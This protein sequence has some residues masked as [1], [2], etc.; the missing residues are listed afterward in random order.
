MFRV[1]IGVG[2]LNGCHK[3]IRRG[4][5][6]V[7]ASVI[8]VF[9][10]TTRVC[11]ATTNT[12]IF[13][14]FLAARSSERARPSLLFFMPSAARSPSANAGSSRAGRLSPQRAV[15]RLSRTA[16]SCLAVVRDVSKYWRAPVCIG[17]EGW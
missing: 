13:D 4:M 7:K 16:S 9:V 6:K 12:C 10:G 17:V 2:A 5:R 8:A 11:A 1:G 14:T 15:W 3:G